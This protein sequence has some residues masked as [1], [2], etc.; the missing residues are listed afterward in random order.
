MSR[1]NQ[2]CSLLEFL[3]FTPPQIKKNMGA[4]W[5][6]TET[7][8]HLF[9]D[10][11]SKNG[12]WSWGVTQWYYVCSACMMTWVQVSDCKVQV[13][14]NVAEVSMSPILYMWNICLCVQLYLLSAIEN[15]K[16]FFLKYDSDWN[17]SS[18]FQNS[19]LFCFITKFSISLFI[20]CIMV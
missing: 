20:F 7:Q 15:Q 1:E 2:K 12:V 11:I 3:S 19:F 16:I 4:L 8:L 17:M 9:T 18:K 6:S 10:L 13:N 14:S 5:K